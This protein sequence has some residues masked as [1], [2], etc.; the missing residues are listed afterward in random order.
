MGPN[1]RTAAG[2][3]GFTLIEMLVSTGLVVLLLSLFAQIF[4]TATRTIGDQRAVA[5]VDGRQRVVD[6]ALRSDLTRRTYRQRRDAAG[7]A[8]GIVPLAPGDVPDG[9][10]QLGYFYISEG[11]P[12]DD[13]DDV[14]QFT[15]RYPV[16]SAGR[17]SGFFEGRSAPIGRPDTNADAVVD[18]ADAD[19]YDNGALDGTAIPVPGPD[20]DQPDFDNGVFNDGL[21]RSSAAE[22]AFFLRGGTLYRRVLLLREPAVASSRDGQPGI[23]P[24]GEYGN[25]LSGRNV[26]SPESFGQVPTYPPTTEQ[27]NYAAADE[28]YSL[29]NDET[30]AVASDGSAVSDWLNDHDVAAI[31]YDRD[32]ELTTPGTSLHV[33]TVDDLRNDGS[34]F[35]LGRPYN[36]SGHVPFV[37]VLGTPVGPPGPAGPGQ[38]LEYL[39]EAA[40]SGLPT[41]FIGRYTAGETSDPDFGYPGVPSLPLIGPAE[42]L[43]YRALGLTRAGGDPRLVDAFER[44]PG[45]IGGPREGDDVL[46]TNVLRFDVEVWDD[47]QQ[48]YIDIGEPLTTASYFGDLQPAVLGLQGRYVQGTT[49]TP[50]TVDERANPLYGPAGAVSPAYAAGWHGGVNAAGVPYRQNFVFDT[51]HPQVDVLPYDPSVGPSAGNGQFEP[52]PLRPLLFSGQAPDVTGA[53]TDAY[54]IGPDIDQLF[55]PAGGGPSILQLYA[56]GGTPAPAVSRWRGSP[57]TSTAPL[58]YTSYLPA[59]ATTADLGAVVFANPA[60]EPYGPFTAADHFLGGGA[61]Q[62]QLPAFPPPQPITRPGTESPSNYQASQPYTTFTDS[63][64]STGP[65]VYQRRPDGTEAFEAGQAIN[66]SIA[67]RLVGGE[68]LDGNGELT[69]GADQPYWPTE[70]GQ[71]VNDGEL[72]WEAVDNRVGLK[73]VRVSV[74]FFDEGSGRIRQLSVEHGLAE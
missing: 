40:V 60:V 54:A 38:P 52:P 2:R 62:T 56:G 24:N 11:E 51:W 72:V 53:T 35:A 68:D 9:D 27:A 21:T 44:R 5:R 16:D 13:T 15:A 32:G 41:P 17:P 64:P 61:F 71:R 36:R 18:G 45:V 31:R 66:G 14:L 1:T 59:T 43:P 26:G 49:G 73:R 20:K 67:F 46:A 8:T 65:V 69:T 10:R 63:T 3:G 12:G 30:D 37:P 58:R 57:S 29:T 25:L 6:A 22:I 42:G 19:I 70:I 7:A 47:L 48:R 74:S 34:R 28:L 4:A 23:G 50:V 39:P 55:Y 33:V